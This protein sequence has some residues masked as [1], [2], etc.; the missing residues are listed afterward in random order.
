MLFLGTLAL[1]QCWFLPGFVFLSFSKLI[2]IEDKFILSP[3]LSL[4]I[5]YL[6]VIFL[7]LLNQFNF[8]NLFLIILFEIFLIGLIYFKHYRLIFHKISNL[9][10]TGLKFNFWVFD[11]F[12]LLFLIIFLFLALNTIGEV[13]HLGDPVVM[14]NEW[15]KDIYRNQI[16][17]TG[18]YPLAYPILGAIT[19]KLL[20]TYEIEFFAR[21]VCLI[22]PLWIFII[23]F[24]LKNL[25]FQHRNILY[26]TF[27]IS[28][29]LIFYIFRHYALFIGYV[30]PILFFI[31]ISLGYLYILMK[32]KELKFIDFL[33]I[34]F[35]ISTPAITKQTGILLTGFIPFILLIFMIREDKEIKISFFLKLISLVFLF[36][37]SWY[38][39]KI[40]IYIFEFGDTSNVKSLMTQVKGSFSYKLLRGLNYAFGIFYPAVIILFLI[41]FKNYYARIIGIFLVLP[42]FLIWSLFFGN[43]NRNLSIAIPIIAFVLSVGLIE[44]INIVKKKISKQILI[45]SSIVIFSSSFF[46]FFELINEKRNR[47][48]LINKNIEKQM[49]RGNNIGTNILIYENLKKFKNKIFYTDDYNFTY[50]PKTENRIILLDCSKLNLQLKNSF[51][52]FSRKNTGICNDS[53]LDILSLKNN[54]YN[55]IFENK[56]H[57][58]FE[59]N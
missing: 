23:Y 56:D 59:F 36:S 39:V 43:D 14:W 27:L 35:A 29:L 57:I 22:Y 40:Y 38:L 42:Y 53:I 15:S 18:D 24:R 16:P 41:S 25:I 46:V 6:L 13:I 7:V 32:D 47:Q 19:Y 10:E 17:S 48:I 54:S 31:T 12:I 50:L 30:D 28:L 21:I 9:K 51:L 11:L 34:V 44:I 49:L 4:F 26:A 37:A 1:F 52:L 20:G 2:K 33:I 3:L 5:N 55:I 45:F 8:K 58:L